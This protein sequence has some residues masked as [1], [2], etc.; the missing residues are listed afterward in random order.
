MA[1]GHGEAVWWGEVKIEGEVGSWRGGVVGRGEEVVWRCRSYCTQE[2]K[3]ALAVYAAVT[4]KAARQVFLD[5]FEQNGGG[6]GPGAFKWVS[7]FSK[8]LIHQQETE[9]A[10]TDDLLTRPQILKH[11]GMS[12]SDFPSKDE[13]FKYADLEIDRNK[14]EFEHEGKVPILLRGCPLLLARCRLLR[15]GWNR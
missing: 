3:Q 4:D 7:S 14:A 9:V 1:R 6:K 11:F 10:S 8:S 5:N 2:A 15:S 12:M 13:A